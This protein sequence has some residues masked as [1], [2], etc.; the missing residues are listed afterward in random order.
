MQIHDS[1]AR[2]LSAVEMPRRTTATLAGRMLTFAALL[3]A[4]SGIVLAQ[5]HD[6]DADDA[7]LPS[8]ARSVSTVPSNGDVNPYGVA[9]V[10][11]N[12]QT[13]SGPLHHGDVLVSNFN[14]SQNLQGTGTTIVRVPTSGPSKPFFQ[15]KPGL[16]LSTALGTLQFGFV[17]VGNFPSTDGSAATA[18]PGSLLVINNHGQLLKSITSP[19]IQGPWDMTLVDGGDHATAFVSNALDGTISRLAFK[20]SS[21]GVSLMSA[22]TIASGYQ[23]RPDAAAFVVAP[24]GSVYDSRRDVLYVASTE[25]NAIFAISDAIDRT[26]DD[27]PG[28]IIYQDNTHLHGPLGMAKAPNGHLLVANADVI[29]SDPKQPSEIVEFTTDG[30]F[31]KQLS[32]DAAQGGSFGLAVRSTEDTA[33]FAAVD[34]NV[35]NITLWQLNLN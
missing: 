3:T 32:M 31:V 2:R 7:F 16:G 28:Q 10:P 30:Q 21:N 11:G 20:V 22:R 34:D 6:Q 33:V 19:K 8:P 25:D 12:F 14:N 9:F 27:G 4:S 29:N 35:P 5:H 13:G 18:Q 17:V 1:I 26:Q 24:T 15:G 23:H